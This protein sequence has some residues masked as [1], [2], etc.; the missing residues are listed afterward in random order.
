MI[1]LLV[2]GGLLCCFNFYLSFVR[3]PVHQMMGGKKEDYQW[4]S[5]I[6]LLG[7][8]LVAISLFRLWQWPWF[9]TP[10][11]IL[12]VID[13]GG[14]HWCAATLLYYEVFRKTNSETADSPIPSEHL[15]SPH[16]S[17]SV[18]QE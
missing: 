12:I 7:S 9:R 1:A 11:I 8:L 5:G 6:P 16:D 2:I 18:E 10:A 14:L 17:P 3:Y 15:P 4:V 13:T